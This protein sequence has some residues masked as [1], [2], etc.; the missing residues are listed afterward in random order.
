[1]RRFTTIHPNT[2]PMPQQ[3]KTFLEKIQS[4][5]VTLSVHGFIS[6]SE[7]GKIKKRIE[8]WIKEHAKGKKDDSSK[9]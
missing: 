4:S 5:R 1:M 8:G 9:N 2:V 6:E 7:N 3:P